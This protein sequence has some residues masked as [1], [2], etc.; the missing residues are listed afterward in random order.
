MNALKPA[1]KGGA[2]RTKP[3]DP[4]RRPREGKKLERRKTTEDNRGEE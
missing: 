2:G 1:V 3:A 4:E